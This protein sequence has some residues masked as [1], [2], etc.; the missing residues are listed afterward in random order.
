VLVGPEPPGFAGIAG[1]QV[2]EPPGFAGIAGHQVL[3]LPGVAGIVLEYA[4]VCRA[5]PSTQAKAYISRARVSSPVYS[6]PQLPISLKSFTTATR[7]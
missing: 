3:E 5:R 6:R 1:H 7:S 2:L 4:V